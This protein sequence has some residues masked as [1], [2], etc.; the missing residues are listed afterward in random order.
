MIYI[1]ILGIFIFLLPVLIIIGLIVNYLT[2]QIF[3]EDDDD[4][5]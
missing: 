5:E 1:F 4:F 3:T 2:H